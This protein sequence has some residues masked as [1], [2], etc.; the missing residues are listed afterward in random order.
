MASEDTRFDVGVVGAGPGGYRMAVRAAELGLRVALIDDGPRPGGVCL[1]VGC[2]PSKALLESSERY[3]AARSELA[4]HGVKV[5]AVELDLAAMMRRKDRVVATMAAGVAYLLEARKIRLYSGRALLQSA[6]AVGVTAP[7][8]PEQR[9]TVDRLVLATG[10]APAALPALPFDHQRVVDSTDALAFDAVPPRLVVVGGGAIGLEMASVWM[11][12]GA[13]VTVVELMPQILPG[14]DAQVARVL[15][16]CLEK[17]GLRILTAASVS[18]IREGGGGLQAVVTAAGKEPVVLDADRV[19]VAVGRRPNTAGLDLAR[20][21][22][23]TDARGFVKTGPGYVTNVANVYAIGDV[24]GMPML[25]HKAEAEGVALAELLAG[26]A[27]QVN[28]DAIPG[29][30][31]TAP[32]VAT[33]GRTEEALK[34]AGVTYRAGVFHFRANGRAQAAG[35]A[36]GLVKVLSEAGS[37]R[38]LGVH[39]VGAGASELIAEAVSV[40][41]FGG[42]AE[43]IGRTVHAHPTLSEAVMHAS[44][45]VEAG[46]A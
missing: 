1:N 25:A 45:A 33:V 12:L 16:R 26:K 40:M 35:R 22:V 46:R 5:G 44:L 43:D 32:E 2:I 17:Q 15:Q 37:D 34:Q 9:L 10:S 23:A 29:V 4:D 38:V 28:Y 20:L 24:R 27:G 39:I 6:T 13:S 14:W 42:S 36:D 8:Q 31:Y 7:G 3:H 41:E 18:A 19:L 30:V 21:G 11:R